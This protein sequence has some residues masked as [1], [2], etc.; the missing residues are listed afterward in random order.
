M[1]PRFAPPT[2][3]AR[4]VWTHAVSACGDACL[5]VSLAG[6]AFFQGPSSGSREKVLLYLLVA[7]A[8]FAV[9]MPILGPALDRTRGGRRLI[10]VLSMVIRAFLAFFLARF[11]TKGGAEGLLVYPLAFSVLVVQKGYS[12]AKSSLVPAVVDDEAELVRANSRLALV[13][14]IASPIGGGAAAL[15]QYLFGADWSL[16][17]AVLVFCVAT[18]TALKIPKVEAA[19]RRPET[20]KLERDELHQPSVLLAAS[21]MA[22]MRAA[23][24]FIVIFAIF[25]LRDDVIGLGAVFAMA[26]G[27]AFIGNLIAPLLRERIREETILVSSVMV[28]GVL[29]MFGA[30][31][32]GVF[33]FAVCALAVA[34]GA[35]TGKLGFDSLLQRDGPD[36]VRG[37]AFARF[38]ARFQLA[39]VIGALLAIIPLNHRVGLLALALTIGFA[40]ISYF[41]ALRTKRLRRTTIRPQ[42][43]DRAFDRAKSELEQRWRRSKGARRQALRARRVAGSRPEAS[44]PDPP[45]RRSR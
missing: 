9:V 13:S 8:P 18:S 32:G 11:V 34:V 4:L 7:M 35:A 2:P 37:R 45:P 28:S 29:A 36:A 12:I 30:V 19:E 42:A 26:G 31:I 10:V 1:D 38:E 14:T 27:G 16:I 24:G 3:F 41:G 39:W 33:G 44:T 25:S 21:A 40:G 23:V 22:V 17:L 20:V 15:I 5:A 43:L 6:S